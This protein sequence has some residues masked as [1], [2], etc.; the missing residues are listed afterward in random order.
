LVLPSPLNILCFPNHGKILA[1][2]EVVDFYEVL[3]LPR[4]ATSPD[5]KAAYHRALLLYHPDKELSTRNRN[6][7]TQ[8]T[9]PAPERPDVAQRLSISDIQKAY[10]TLADPVL[11]AA[12]DIRLVRNS[13]PSFT[14]KGS[15][16]PAEIISFDE[17]APEDRSDA[18]IYPC[19]CGSVYRIT[20][21]QLEADV[22]L[23]GC[24]GCSE[25]V[26]VGY[27]AVEEG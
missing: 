17:F 21:E 8:N 23:I 6:E 22:H 16:R 25:V 9:V 20:E 19:R 15:Q 11:R 10:A 24:Q 12:F 13:T 3:C 14:E 18:Y 7:L 2:R 27:E 5:V 4:T 26:W 1:E